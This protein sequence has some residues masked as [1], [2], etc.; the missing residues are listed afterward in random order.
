M[1]EL[2][3][4]AG[5]RLFGLQMKQRFK[6]LNNT[7]KQTER[8]TLEP[9]DAALAR[10]PIGCTVRTHSSSY[11][12]EMTA[13]GLRAAG[14]LEVG[15]AATS[16]CPAF[17]VNYKVIGYRSCS[18]AARRRKAAR[19]EREDAAD[20]TRRDEHMQVKQDGHRDACQ[21]NK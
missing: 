4:G 9:Q 1:P 2:R 3:G 14:T 5:F 10:G 8:G 17:P 20:A 15:R 18:R 6:V 7:L 13:A 11:C 12:I 19:H 16:C 21:Q